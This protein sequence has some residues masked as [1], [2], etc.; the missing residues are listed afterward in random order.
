MKNPPANAGDSGDSGSI[1]GSGRSPG[2]GSGNPLIF[3]PRESPWTEEPVGY[4][5]WGSQRADTTEGLAR[6]HAKD[7]K[8]N[9]TGQ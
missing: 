7:K 9:Q 1:P 3:L 8:N 6:T 4:S 2:G 5:L